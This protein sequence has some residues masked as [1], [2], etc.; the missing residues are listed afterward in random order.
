MQTRQRLMLF[1]TLISQKSENTQIAPHQFL[2]TGHKCYATEGALGIDLL[3]QTGHRRCR[4]RE[5]DLST[6]TMAAT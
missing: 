3:A 1:Y 2:R 4:R 5:K 6:K